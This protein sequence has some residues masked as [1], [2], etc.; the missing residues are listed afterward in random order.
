MKTF[1]FLKN[2]IV[3]F[4][5]LFFIPSIIMS[6]PHEDWETTKQ[7]G[8]ASKVGGIQ[9]IDKLI[10]YS[11]LFNSRG[12]NFGF[13]VAMGRA[14]MEDENYLNGLKQL[15]SEGHKLFDITPNLRT[16]IL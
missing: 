16:N 12:Y 7:G 6:Q 9:P 8:V 2:S 10:E 13:A 4:I 15:Q 3:I 1:K 5:S 11:E 14:E